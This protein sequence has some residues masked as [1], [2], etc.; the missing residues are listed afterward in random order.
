M[1]LAGPEKA[2]AGMY[3]YYH[4]VA[5][6]LHAYGEPVLTDPKGVKHD[7]RAEFADKLATLQKPDGSWVGEKSWMENNPVLTTAFVVLALEQVRQDLEQH[8]VK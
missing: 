5:A 1:K 8:P 6:A 4:T 3:Y 2:Q 7:W